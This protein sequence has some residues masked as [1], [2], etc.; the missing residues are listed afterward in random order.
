MSGSPARAFADLDLALARGLGLLATL[1]AYPDE[2]DAI[3][4]GLE[5][6]VEEVFDAY[7]RLVRCDDAITDIKAMLLV[8]Y[9][10]QPG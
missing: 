7:A 9:V 4:K 1:E 2:V 5:K 3:A 10:G 6:V 8:S